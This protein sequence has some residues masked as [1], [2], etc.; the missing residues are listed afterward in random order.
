MI[1][2]QHTKKSINEEISL[3]ELIHYVGSH[4]SVILKAYASD[5]K[6]IADKWEELCDKHL[7]NDIVTK[8]DLLNLVEDFTNYILD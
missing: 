6:T 5:K 2:N 4:L 1:I 7:E 3:E 8:A